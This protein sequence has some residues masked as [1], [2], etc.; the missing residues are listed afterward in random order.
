MWDTVL[1]SDKGQ[2]AFA[3]PRGHAKST[4]ITHTLVLALTLFR[5]RKYCLIV[6]D[7]EAQ[8]IQFLGDIKNQLLENEALRRDFGIR[9][10]V[11]DVSADVIVEF[12][13]GKQF[14]IQ[15][16]GSG[17]K[18]RG[19][20][21][22]HTRPDL[23]VCDD[24]E[25]DEAVQSDVSRAKHKSWFNNA[26][27]QS[28]GVGGLIILVGTILHMDSVLM[29]AIKSKSWDSR[30]YKA[31]LDFDDF[32]DLLWPEY[33]SEKS[34][35]AKRQTFI[36][37]GNPEGYAQEF[38]NDPTASS[39]NFF[40]RE[41]FKEIDDEM[42]ERRLTYYAGVDLAISDMDK[43]AYTVI[44]IGGMDESRLLH[45]KNVIRFRGD[46]HDIIET[47]FEVQKNYSISLWKVEEGQIKRTLMGPILEKMN[48][49]GIYLNISPGVPT[50]DK[51]SRARAIQARMRAGGVVVDKEAHWYPGFEQELIQFPK[52]MYK[53]QVDAVAWLGHAIN[54]LME[55]PT[56]L[57]R[58][59]EDYED[60]V[61]E[62]YSQGQGFFGFNGGGRSPICGY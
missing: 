31:H 25:N 4:S 16:L 23:I 47:M 32:S 22:R 45:I 28:L 2:V 39:D 43:A 50:K 10:F 6:S 38:L 62:N 40:K 46:A 51:R 21:W 52:G 55:A 34:L 53:D 14:R 17:Q 33:H 12:V 44:V 1:N 54:E 35:R 19:R 20:I 37:D 7:T 56:D 29:G 3:A 57:E 61:N 26:L 41:F 48:T 42:R 11:K 30:L 24:F 8:A 9:R 18:A 27:I 60:R 59:Q 36:D 13:D 58:E 15:A 5:A 49:T